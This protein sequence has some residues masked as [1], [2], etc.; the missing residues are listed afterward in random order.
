MDHTVAAE[1]A[2]GAATANHATLRFNYR[3]VGGSQGKVSGE[4]HLSDALAALAFL[5]ETHLN[6]PAVVSIGSSARVLAAIAEQ[7]E[8]AGLA[9]VSPAEVDAQTLGEWGWKGLVILAEHDLRMPRA[10]VA[11]AIAESG[12]QME[13]VAGADRHFR[14]NLVQVGRCIAA[15]LDRLETGKSDGISGT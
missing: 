7:R 4:S 5:E 2:W 1:I 15:W 6:P 12:G 14:K 8:L 3:G 10:S 9:A 11:Q 13:L